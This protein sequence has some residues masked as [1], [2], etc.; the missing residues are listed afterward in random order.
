MTPGEDA[1]QEGYNGIFVGGAAWVKLVAPSSVLVELTLLNDVH[2]VFNS[3]GDVVTD[4]A[5]FFEVVPLI[6]L[7]VVHVIFPSLSVANDQHWILRLGGN[8]LLIL[9]AKSQ[10]CAGVV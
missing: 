9:F 5:P 8:P 6:D 2:M 3:G 1:G 4:V 10:H 7:Y